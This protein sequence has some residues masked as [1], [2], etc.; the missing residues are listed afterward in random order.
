MTTNYY[1]NKFIKLIKKQYIFVPLVAGLLWLII[2]ELIEPIRLAQT[3][4]YTFNFTHGSNYTLNITNQTLERIKKFYYITSAIGVI[5]L[6]NSFYERFLYYPFSKIKQVKWYDVKN[7]KYPYDP[8]KLQLIIGQV[9]KEDSTELSEVP[10]YETIDEKGLFQNILI[11]GTIGTGK[12][13]AAI[14]QIALQLIYLFSGISEDK[15]AM[16]FLDVKGNFYK[17]VHAFAKECGRWKDVITIELG[18]Q[19]SYNPL[20]KPSLSEIELANRIRYVLDLF[21]PTGGQGETYWI[22]KAEDTIT[23]LLKLIRLY[24]NGYV[25]FA[26]LHEVGTKDN[27]RVEKINELLGMLKRNELNDEQA[28]KLTT[29]V[30]YFKNEFDILP[31]KA[32]AFIK[33][34]ITRMTQPFISTKKVK[35]T[36][37]PNADEINFYG[38]EDVIRKGKIVVWKINANKEPKVAKI[39]AA[40]LKLDFQKEIMISLE[41]SKKDPVSADRIKVMMC[42]EYQE[43]STVNDAEFLSQ[44]REPRTI[45]VA[46]TQSYS[47]IKKA[48]KNDETVTNMLLQSFV[49]KIWLRSDDVEYTIPK[50]MK[51]IGKVIKEKVTTSITE[52]ARNSKVNYSLGTVLGKD[53]N[54]SSGT[55]I[56]EQKEYLFDETFLGQELNEGQAVCFL[57][58]GKKI[59]KPKV[60]HLTKLYEGRIIYIEDKIRFTTDKEEIFKNIGDIDLEKLEIET[61]PELKK[62]DMINI[63]KVL[64]FEDNDVEPRIYNEPMLKKKV[65]EEKTINFISEEPKIEQN[66]VKLDKEEKESSYDEVVASKE[67]VERSYEDN[68][69]D[70]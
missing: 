70:N 38:F 21:S 32:Q 66:I 53:K 61:F 49:N 16:L 11:T 22:D 46:S 58:D 9:Y 39:I 19:W 51:Q 65:E 30:S 7:C 12:T 34:E 62:E 68:I 8:N 25:N 24:N 23:E 27:Y 18:G 41:R 69:F 37:C 6:A 15:A 45:T 56:T 20:H 59:K 4:S 52:S 63:D 67:E 48:L 5:A 28:Y 60:V 55:T 64:A 33:S 40:Y 36:F 14:T 44:S 42:D 10:Y 17:F 26:E 43:Y 29:V 3:F 1:V 50:V 13:I 35:D 2:Y 54:L 47:S 57:S 31:D